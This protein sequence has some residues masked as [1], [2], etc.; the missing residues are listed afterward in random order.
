MSKLRKETQKLKTSPHHEPKPSM[1]VP[2][3][4]LTCKNKVGMANMNKPNE[5]KGVL[6]QNTVAVVYSMYTLFMSASYRRL[7][8]F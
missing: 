2:V 4:W 6:V 1:C 5:L 3:S 7:A 8:D